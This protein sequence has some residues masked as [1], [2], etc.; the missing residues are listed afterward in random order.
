MGIEWKLEGEAVE[1]DL[2]EAKKIALERLFQARDRRMEELQA[3]Y[4][5]NSLSG[6]KDGA[7]AAVVECGVLR[8]EPDFEPVRNSE[9]VADL[10][11]IT[12]NEIWKGSQDGRL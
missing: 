1:I 12:I 7:Q 8:L 6:D 5:G 3:T 9:T 4:R 2:T 11:R 10:A